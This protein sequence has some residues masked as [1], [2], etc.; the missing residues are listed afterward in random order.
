VGIGIVRT[1][2]WELFEH[3]QNQ[4]CFFGCTQGFLRPFCQIAFFAAFV[5]D[6]VKQ[7]TVE[8]H[9]DKPQIF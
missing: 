7:L 4:F 1:L 2:G 9:W 6:S 3:G 8:L 5:I